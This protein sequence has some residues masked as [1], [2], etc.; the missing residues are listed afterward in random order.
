[1]KSGTEL[2]Q[3]LKSFLPTATWYLTVRFYSVKMCSVVLSSIIFRPEGFPTYFSDTSFRV[4]CK[5]WKMPLIRVIAECL[6][7]CLCKIK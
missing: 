2:S 4:L 5:Q 1:M 7:E 3:S 6:K